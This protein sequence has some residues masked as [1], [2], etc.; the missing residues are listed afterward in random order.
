MFFSNPLLSD[1]PASILPTPIAP[2]ITNIS[3]LGSAGGVDGYRSIGG[4]FTFTGN[5]VGIGEGH[6]RAE[7]Q[8]HHD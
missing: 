4:Q 5:V 6:C 8:F 1:L 2:T 7:N 3:Y